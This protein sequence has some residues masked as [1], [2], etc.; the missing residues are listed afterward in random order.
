MKLRYVADLS[1]S[2]TVALLGFR[3]GKYAAWRRHRQR[4]DLVRV[5][6]QARKDDV[7][8]VRDFASTLVDPGH[9]RETRTKRPAKRK[10]VAGSQPVF[11]SPAMFE[12]RGKKHPNPHETTREI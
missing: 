5:E 10:Q 2:S 4:Q 6:V 11:D 12:N 1:S 9:E 3:V 8:L 7:A